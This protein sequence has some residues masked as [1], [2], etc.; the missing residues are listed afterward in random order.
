LA[1][2]RSQIA[3]LESQL[4]VLHER[5]QT[6]STALDSIVY[7]ILALPFDMTAEIFVHYLDVPDDVY[8]SMPTPLILAS[9]C[10][11]WRSI[12]LSCPRLW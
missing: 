8:I 5:Q 1:Q 12:A 6:V 9:V 2:I 10:S 11:Q 4:A 7:P 3:A